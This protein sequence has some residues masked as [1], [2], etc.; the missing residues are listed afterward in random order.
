MNTDRDDVVSASPDCYTIRGVFNGFQTNFEYD[1]LYRQLIKHAF[2]VCLESVKPVKLWKRVTKFFTELG[3]DPS[4]F[5]MRRFESYDNSVVHSAA[6]VEYLFSHNTMP[7]MAHVQ[8]DAFDTNFN[9]NIYTDDENVGRVTK[10]RDALMRTKKN[11]PDNKDNFYMISH[12]GRCFEL[13]RYPYEN[14]K[15]ENFSIEDFYNDDF[16]EVAEHI[17]DT[18]Q[19]PNSQ[20]IALLHGIW[21]SG[22]TSFLRHL[23]CTLKKKVI[24]FPPDMTPELASPSFFSFIRNHPDSV[25]IIEDAENILRKREGGGNQAISN[26]LNIS[27]GIV[28]DA[29][30]IQMVCTFNAEL[31]D[32][33]DA[34]KRP[35]R[36]IAQYHFNTLSPEKTLNLVKKI[37]GENEVPTQRQMT[38]AEVFSMKSKIFNKEKEKPT[39]GFL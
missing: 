27:D 37:Y 3:V 21:G 17:I 34:L 29:L 15:Q 33:D 10:F 5:T 8:F 23:I 31:T 26:L 35:G 9:V 13:L 4:D 7:V 14:N 24:Y 11:P 12:N 20:G 6:H 39:M 19:T 22:K 30:R 2:N 18:L 1:R 32:I 25:L 36:L 38:L 28:G 16:K